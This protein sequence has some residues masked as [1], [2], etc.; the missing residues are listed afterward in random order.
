M[1]S[2]TSDS[3]DS[4]IGLSGGPATPSREA[5][6]KQL[7]IPGP[8]V[9]RVE[10]LKELRESCDGIEFSSLFRRSAGAA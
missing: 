7:N 9:G 3:S 6:A 5:E 4:G 8:K 10:T 1:A 2:T